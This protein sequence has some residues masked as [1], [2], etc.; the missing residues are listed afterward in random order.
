MLFYSFFWW[1]YHIV[2]LTQQINADEYNMSRTMTHDSWEAI[3]FLLIVSIGAFYVI[4]SYY[5]EIELVKKEKTFPFL[6]LTN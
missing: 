2:S 4:R 1:G 3:V 5:K 6:L